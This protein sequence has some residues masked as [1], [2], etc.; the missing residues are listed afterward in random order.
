MSALGTKNGYLSPKV[1]LERLSQK[2]VVNYGLC[3]N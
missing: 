2:A 1:I 3:S